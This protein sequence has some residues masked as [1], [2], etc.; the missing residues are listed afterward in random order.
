LLTLL[1]QSINLSARLKCGLLYGIAFVITISP[2]LYRNYALY[3]TVKLSSIQG[4]SLLIWQVATVRAWETNQTRKAIADEYMAGAKE[5]GYTKG[6]NPFVDEKIEQKLAIQYI[7]TKPWI[8]ASRWINGMFH[9][10]FNLNS[11]N[12]IVKRLGGL[13]EGY[14]ARD[15]TKESNLQRVA[16]FFRSNSLSKIASGL[17]ELI[18][19]LTNYL[20]FL[21]GWYT[22][23]R[24]RQYLI[25]AI[26]TLGVLYFAVVGGPIGEGRYRL[27]ATPFYLLVGAIYID[28][29]LNRRAMQTEASKAKTALQP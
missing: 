9:I 23:A 27:P 25:L 22:L 26:L 18:L 28:Q 2:W 3:D 11:E 13:P 20:M 21:L 16:N 12:I 1:F 6:G 5:L 29:L 17:I 10:Y 4:H 15:S 19:L 7:K 24:Q 14:K 8:F